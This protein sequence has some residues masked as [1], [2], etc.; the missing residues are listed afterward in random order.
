M[1]NK[2]LAAL[3]LGAALAS[4]TVAADARTLKLQASSAPG[5]W[6]HRFMTENWSKKLAAMSGS[7]SRKTCW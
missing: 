5:D 2:T 4:V 7:G 1:A 3:A 6:A